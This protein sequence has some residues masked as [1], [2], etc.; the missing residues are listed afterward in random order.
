MK[1]RKTVSVTPAMG[2][3]TVAGA[4]VTLPMERPAETGLGGPA[5]R[6]RS[7]ELVEEMSARIVPGFAHGSILLAFQTKAPAARRGLDFQGVSVTMRAN[8]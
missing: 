3:R 2:A 1:R 4:I 6:T 7:P 5:W 8:P